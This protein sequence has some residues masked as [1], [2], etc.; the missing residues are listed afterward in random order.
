MKEDT[1]DKVTVSAKTY[2]DSEQEEINAEGVYSLCMI[3]SDDTADS[4]KYI[5]SGD[6]D[7]RKIVCG[8]GAVLMDFLGKN[9]PAV[10]ERGDMYAAMLSSIMDCLH[11]NDRETFDATMKSMK[12][13]NKNLAKRGRR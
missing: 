5:T 7:I 3:L 4:S 12:E 11:E 10:E 9:I 1:N 8:W 2:N 6:A 13:L